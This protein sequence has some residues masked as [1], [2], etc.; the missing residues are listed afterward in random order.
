MK[1]L[2]APL[3]LITSCAPISTQEMRQVIL[4][5]KTVSESAAINRPQGED[6]EEY[7]KINAELWHELYLYYGLNND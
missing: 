7:L 3:F 2:L 5:G 1:I 4:T 6:L